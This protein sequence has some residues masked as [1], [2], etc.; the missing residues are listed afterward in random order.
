ASLVGLV[1]EPPDYPGQAWPA[2]F[3]EFLRARIPN[4]Y[5]EE[6]ATVNGFIPYNEPVV[7]GQTPMVYPVRIFRA[8]ELDADFIVDAGGR[9][10]GAG[11]CGQAI[12]LS[13]GGGRVTTSQDFLVG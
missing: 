1:S 4:G 7:V 13:G 9:G 3:A 12:R 8:P 5:R 10:G 2:R 11:V 6:F